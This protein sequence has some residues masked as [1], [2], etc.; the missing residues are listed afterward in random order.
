MLAFLAITQSEILWISVIEIV[1]AAFFCRFEEDSDT[2]KDVRA[3]VEVL[4]REGV[5]VVMIYGEIADPDSRGV[6]CAVI[7]GSVIGGGTA[8][9]AG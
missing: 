3:V 8:A 1:P 5:P 4:K 2:V 7:G 9:G 6:D